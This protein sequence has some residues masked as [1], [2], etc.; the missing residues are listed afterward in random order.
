M[1]MTNKLAKAI[2]PALTCIVA[3]SE[4]AELEQPRRFEIR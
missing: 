2:V 4:V 3:T 1:M